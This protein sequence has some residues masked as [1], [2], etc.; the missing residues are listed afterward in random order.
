MNLNEIIISLKNDPHLWVKRQYTIMH[1]NRTELWN[2]NIPFI[3][4]H[5]YKP[6]KSLSIL[7]K[8]KLQLAINKWLKSEGIK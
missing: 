6:R 3:N 8:I 4:A 5:I 2:S 1:R 7:G